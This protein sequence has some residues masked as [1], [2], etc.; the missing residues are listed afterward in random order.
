[1][2]VCWWSSFSQRLPNSTVYSESGAITADHNVVVGI[3]IQRLD[4][5]RAGALILIAQVAAEFNRPRRLAARTST[6]PS[7]SPRR[8]R[9]ACGGDQRRGR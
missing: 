1:L 3:N 4:A 5:D 8:T 2:G 7:H 6:S 9:Q